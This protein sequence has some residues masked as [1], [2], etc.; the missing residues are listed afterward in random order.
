MSGQSW[1][2]QKQ[3]HISRINSFPVMGYKIW[4]Y[5][6]SCLP[7]KYLSI[8]Y[9]PHIYLRYGS[10]FTP[11]DNIQIGVF[12]RL[13]SPSAFPNGPQTFPLS[14]LWLLLS[15]CIFSHS[16][17]DDW[18]LLLWTLLHA[19]SCGWELNCHHFIIKDWYKLRFILP[20]KSECQ[21][22]FLKKQDT[23][24]LYSKLWPLIK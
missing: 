13:T 11:T 12:S 6:I 24:S 14:S 8:L 5:F 2:L 18:C 21:P 3:A 19:Y 17:K 22:I 7:F 16:C 15:S 1:Q 9:I 4:I 10:F 23:Y 20:F